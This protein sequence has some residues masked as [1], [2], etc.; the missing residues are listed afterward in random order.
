MTTRAI[1]DYRGEKREIACLG[2][3]YREAGEDVP[4]HILSA[5]LFHA[6][7]DHEIPIPG[8]VILSTRRHIKSI[9]EFTDEEAREFIDLVRR[10]R[11][12]LRE[13]LGIERIYFIQEE[14]TPDHFHVWFLPRYEWM[15]DEARFGRKVSSARPVLEYAREHLKTP[16]NLEAVE[17][18][19]RKLRQA[20]S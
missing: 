12:A 16:E 11:R 3:Y 19:V 13:A 7:Q 5:D 17:T 4:G 8:F 15:E 14:D 9:D 18:V 2:C 10:I 6:H 1:E 20:L